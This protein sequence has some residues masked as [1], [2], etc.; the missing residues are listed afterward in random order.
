MPRLR[1]HNLSMSFDGYMAGPGQGADEPLGRGGEALHEWIFETPSG[2]RMMGQGGGTPGIDEDFMARSL[3]GIGATIMGR[4]MFG[5]VRGGW[6][7]QSWQGW[8]GDNPPFHHPV[9]VLTHHPRASFSMN[10]GTTFHFVTGGIHEALDRAAEAAGGLDIRL[11]GGALADG[12]GVRLDARSRSRSSRGAGRAGRWSRSRRCRS[13]CYRAP[14]VTWLHSPTCGQQRKTSRMRFTYRC[15]CSV[16]TRIWQT[17]KL[18]ITC[19][20]RW[21]FCRDCGGATRS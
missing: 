13:R 8:W 15:R 20:K 6:P 17:C 4:N 16:A 10:G 21:R 1:V 11:G 3:E 19:T 14:W 18:R 9:F 2:K 12:R 5:P 7:D